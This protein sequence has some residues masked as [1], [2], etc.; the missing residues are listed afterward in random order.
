MARFPSVEWEQRSEDVRRCRAVPFLLPQLLISVYTR[1]GD[2]YYVDDPAGSF[3]HD[4]FY[5]LDAGVRHTVNQHLAQAFRPIK[6]HLIGF[7]EQQGWMA[8]S[9]AQAITEPF[10]SGISQAL[11]QG[12]NPHAADFESFIRSLARDHDYNAAS[13]Q[14]SKSKED[15]AS[16]SSEQSSDQ[17]EESPA[18][19]QKEVVPPGRAYSCTKSPY[20]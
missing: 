19:V 5:A 7:A 15:L 2:E 20:F 10:L 14:K 11:K 4:L 16:S 13:S 9:G 12:N 1:R 18:K 8:P 6:H 17:E 3:E